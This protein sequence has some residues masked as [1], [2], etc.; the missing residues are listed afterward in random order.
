MTTLKKQSELYSNISYNVWADSFKPDKGYL[1]YT[2]LKHNVRISTYIDIKESLINDYKHGIIMLAYKSVNSKRA[3]TSKQ[4][5]IITRTNLTTQL[6]EYKK[7]MDDTAFAE[8]KILLLNDEIQDTT[9]GDNGI[10]CLFRFEKHDQTNEFFLNPGAALRNLTDMIGLGVFE[11]ESINEVLD[12]IIFEMVELFFNEIMPNIKLSNTIS[13][14]ED[15]TR[16]LQFCIYG[17]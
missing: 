16:Y 6:L 9:L 4:S 7:V 1:N 12:N 10:Q 14:K 2:L 11:C 15:I 17:E 13:L 3:R 8:N 5:T